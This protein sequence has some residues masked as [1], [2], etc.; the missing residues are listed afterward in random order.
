MPNYKHELRPTVGVL[1][2][3]HVYQ[4]T[5]HSFLDPVLR[6]IQLAARERGS[7]LLLACGVTAG[8]HTPRPAWPVPAPDVD[9]V[10]VGPWNT[11]GLI[12]VTS[13]CSET[14]STY[15]QQW[16]AAGHPVVYL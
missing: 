8:P 6:G 5:L 16:R 2:G 11:D 9:F 10:P 14:R 1:A 13:L 4:G 12:A 3:W 7:N 15:I